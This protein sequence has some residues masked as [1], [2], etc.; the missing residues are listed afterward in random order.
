[1]IRQRGCAQCAG[2]SLIGLAVMMGIIAVLVSTPM[3]FIFRQDANDQKKT[4]AL[5]KADQKA[6]IG[7]AGAKGRLPA[8]TE[9]ASLVPSPRDGNEQLIGYAFDSQLAN[10]GSICGKQITGNDV[11]SLK[12]ITSATIDNVAFIVWSN[13]RN[14]TTDTP[15]LT[16]LAPTATPVAVGFIPPST[17]YKITMDPIQ[18][19]ILFWV[20]LAELQTAAHCFE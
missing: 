6:V 19:D 8:A 20:T 4:R 11:T 14:G 9:F 15:V 10:A 3:Y 13:G 18:D 1:M 5:L 17:P 2:F 7:F 12:V 16:V